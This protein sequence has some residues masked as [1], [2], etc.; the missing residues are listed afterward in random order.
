VHITC[1]NCCSLWQ[2]STS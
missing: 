1:W 2:N